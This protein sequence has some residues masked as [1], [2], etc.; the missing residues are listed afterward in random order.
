MTKAM[1]AAL[2]R[3]YALTAEMESMKVENRSRRAGGFAEA[4]DSL[5]FMRI[6]EQLEE[7]ARSMS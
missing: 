4:Y 3:I 1:V 6:S 5:A 7:I 2:A